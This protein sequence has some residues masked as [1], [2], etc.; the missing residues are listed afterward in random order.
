MFKNNEKSKLNT[1]I[2]GCPFCLFVLLIAGC[3]SES[4]IEDIVEAQIIEDNAVVS[5]PPNILILIADDLGV[6]QLASFGIGS[7]PAVTPNLDQLA[8]EGISFSNVWVQPTCSPTRATLLTGRYGFQTGVGV[9]PGGSDGDYPG[10]A[11][12]NGIPTLEEFANFDISQK[13]HEIYENIGPVFEK[14]SKFYI[15]ADNDYLVSRPQSMGLPT[16]E[17]TLPE[18]FRSSE[19]AYATGVIGK[20]H[21]GDGR[22]GWLQHP[23]NAGFDFYSVNMLNQPESFFAW[24]ENTNGD[25]EQRTGYT[26]TQKIDDAI[27]WIGQQENNPWFLWLAFNLPHYPHH[28]P[29]VE[30]LDTSSTEASDPRAALDV[31]TSRMDQ[32]IGRLFEAIGEAE[33]EN[34]IIVFIGDNGTTGEANDPPFHPD[35]GKFT[36][37]EGGLRVPLIISGA[38]IPGGQI[39][40]GLVNGADLYATLIELAG[41]SMPEQVEL[42]SVSLTPYFGNPSRE[43]VRDYIFADAF[44][45]TRGIDEGAFAIRNST[46]KLIRWHDHQELYDLVSDPY[47]NNDLLTDG[48][49]GDEAIILDELETL[50]DNLR[51]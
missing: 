18:V 51:N 49:T 48:I 47:E 36:L 40:T 20:W 16:S 44:Y 23:G 17:L 11:R 21:L 38:G 13:P 2:L 9:P 10:V 28:V 45:S 43:S 33:L 30:S 31:M 3:N 1:K 24:Y 46:H 29:V 37:Y 6:E 42:N 32:E 22:N 39:S 35:R 25:L 8:R 19:F 14:F 4:E 26:P 50:V 7:S 5:T 27:N 34:T 41:I 12:E 15:S